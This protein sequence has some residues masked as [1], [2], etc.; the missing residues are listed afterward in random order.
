MAFTCFETITDEN[1]ELI[2]ILEGLVNVNDVHEHF[3]R[4]IGE[5][6]GDVEELLI[7]LLSLEG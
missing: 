7:I 1:V 4:A 5:C 2:L 3:E 6:V